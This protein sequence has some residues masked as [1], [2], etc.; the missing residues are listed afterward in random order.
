MSVD[1]VLSVEGLAVRYGPRTVLDGV[2]FDVPRGTVFA[3]LGRNGTG[4]SSLV[5]CALGQ[6]K[7]TR[8]ATRLFGEDAWAS[9]PRAMARIGVVPEEPDAPPDMTAAELLAFCAP[10]YET[11]DDAAARARLERSAVPLR[12]PFG[13]LSKGQKGAVMLALALAAA[14]ELLILDDPTLG[15]DAVA[16]R[17]LYDELI[18]DLA[19]RGTTALVTTHDLDGIEPIADRVAVLHGSR[20]VANEGLDA[21]KARFRRVR[22]TGMAGP[23]SWEPF[24]PIATVEKDWGRE[25]VVTNFTEERRAAFV[26]RAGGSDVEVAALSLEEIFLALVGTAGARS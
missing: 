24:E 20:L 3:L 16:R 17:A 15:L 2:S 5:R 23:T 25:A 21:L 12:A 26:A 22:C 4:K 18:G 1:A 7:P 8:G 6:Q 19:D 10:L 11:W 9:R 14:P 13:T